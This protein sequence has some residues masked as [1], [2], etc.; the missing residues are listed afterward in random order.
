MMGLPLLTPLLAAAETRLE[1]RIEWLGAPDAW[2][3]ALIV[4]PALLLGVWWVYRGERG[5]LTSGARTALGAIRLAVLL[6]LVAILCRPTLTEERVQRENSWV[7]VLVD[8]SYSMG[9]S[10]RYADPAVRQQLESV[11]G[12]PYTEETNR[13]DLVRAV[14]GERSSFVEDLR[15]KANVRIVSCSNGIQL[16]ADLLRKDERAPPEPPQSVD[17]A[18]LVLRG[19]VTRLGDSIYESVN[20]LRG[21]S[22]AAVVLFSDGQD[23][24]GVVRPEEAAERLARREIPIH[25]IGVGNAEDPRDIRVFHLDIAEVVLAEDLVPV[26]FQVASE[27]FAGESVRAELKLLGEDGRVEQEIRRSVTLGE[28]GEI[29]TIRL[30]FRPRMAGRFIA[31]VEIEAQEGE[32]FREN[33]FEEKPITVLDQ[34]IKVLYVEG[35]PRYD[36]RYLMH[37]LVRDPTMESQILLHSADPEYIQESSPG[38]PPLDRF[39]RTREEL[40]EYHVVVLGDVSEQMFTGEQLQW[41]VEF[42]DDHGGGV[43]FLAGRWNMPSQYRGTPL[44]RLF[45]VELEDAESATYDGGNITQ[46][47]NIRLTPEGLEHPVMQLVGDPE[48][49]QRLWEFTG[50]VDDSLP[51]FFW[52]QRVKRV[53]RGAVALA[54]HPE[55]SNITMEP[56]PLFAFQYL[57]RGR[58]FISLTDDTWRLRKLVGNRWFYRFWGQVIRFT[59][60]GRLLGESKR[61]SVSTDQREYTL[62]GSIRVLARA[63]GRDFKPT[64]D[65]ERELEIERIGTSEPPAEVTAIQNPARPE[66]YEVTLEAKELGEHKVTLS[67]GS[68]E[69]AHTTYRVVVPQLEYEDPR[70]DRARLTEIARLSGGSYHEIGE[71]RAVVDEV[72]P[73]EK[74]VPIS[75]ERQPLWD[76]KWLLLAFI[77]LLTAEWLLRKAFRLL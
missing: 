55:S 5:G 53:K 71:T 68:E 61:F 72:K 58:T 47:F 31:R 60:A 41:L 70:M 23:N 45:P 54:V 29:D 67:D 12:A 34:K 6:L 11:L 14:L 76:T 48:E 49:N 7:L 51:G 42:V 22:V 38:V 77:S 64:R 30:E 50:R 8:D 65:E 69:V 73:F 59:S 16:V 18:G 32:L 66:Y 25:T 27:G 35:P 57:G 33:N 28:A 46:A 9:I 21:E 26:D 63:L 36:Y 3:I 20:E 75:E 10:D 2:V 37:A 74:E 4:I 52:F 17:L 40:F 19:R 56:R 44:E 43:V 39:P 13:L 62:G 15:A 1:T 24:G